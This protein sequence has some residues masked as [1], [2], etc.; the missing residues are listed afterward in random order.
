MNPYILAAAAP[1]NPVA[2]IAHQFGV[3]WQ[4]L[5]SQIIL[6]VIVALALKKFAYAPILEM[7]E[8]R[9]QT[10]AE[11]M[12]NAE[13]IKAELANAQA[14]SQEIMKEAGVQATKMIE[15]ARA[16]AAKI[17]ETEAQKAVKAA[18]QII[19]KAREASET[20][21]NRMMAELKREIGHLA[22]KAAMQVTGKV[23]TAEDQQR[24]AEE[25]NRQ[26]AA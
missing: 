9:R 17:S 16:A 26:L 13:K 10:I 7:L 22:V 6:F 11:S 14:K 19:A 3:N 25:T 24:L 23:L 5:I 12:D 20:D 21:R 2:E 8:K 4:L 15:E 18:E 1:G